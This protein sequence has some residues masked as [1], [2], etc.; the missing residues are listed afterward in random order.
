MAWDNQEFAAIFNEH[1]PGLC[2]FLECMMGGNG[3]AQ[4][5]AQETFVRLFRKGCGAIPTEE[6]R[7][8]IYRVA[9]NLALNEL[10]KSGTRHRLF[11]KVLGLN[12]SKPVTNPE[13]EYEQVERT[14][15]LRN[16]L[17]LLPEQLRAALMLR[18]QQEMTYAEI[19]RVLNIS[20]SKVKI[21]I[22]RARMR[23]RAEWNE[24]HEQKTAIKR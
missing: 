10:K 8:W 11:D 19:A 14:Q 23:L 18:D 9:R 22:H 13:Q 1:Y 20:E 12:S 5:I 4:D 21:D 15:V 17:R 24:I 16:L 3:N 6:V 2:R 7:F